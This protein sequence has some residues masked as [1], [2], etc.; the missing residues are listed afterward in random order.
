MAKECLI[1]KKSMGTFS[2]KVIVS[3]GYVCMECW[4]KAGFDNSMNT[5]MTG[6]QYSSSTLKEMIEVKEKNQY[7]IDNFEATKK[8]GMLS[9]D[10]NT[11]TF[12]ITKSKNNKDIYK[13]NQI[14]DFEL[15]EDGETITKGGL[16]RAV[17]GGLLFG[18]V[19][20]VVGG[21]TGSKKT[22]SVC[23]SMQIKITLRNTPRQTEYLSFITTE[24]KTSGFIY[25]TS[26]K[27]AQDVL[28]ALQIAVDMVNTSTVQESAQTISGADEIMKYKSLLDMG[29]I[30]QEE[31][32]AKK[33]QLLGL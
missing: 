18:G 23:K 21:V 26:Y 9:F 25:Q 33:K 32:D 24:V 31:F 4:I 13:Y 20:A 6:N 15:L 7:L 29:I 16:G 28:S 8:V 17:A 1:C 30:S 10:D 27:T 5:F 11:Q 14:V 19:G 12:I 2:S 3:D 22:K